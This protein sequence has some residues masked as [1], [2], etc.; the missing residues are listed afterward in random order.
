MG[1]E[2]H[3]DRF[4]DKPQEQWRIPVDEW[5]RPLVYRPRQPEWWS[6]SGEWR[7]VKGVMRLQYRRHLQYLAN[8]D[9]YK[10]NNPWGLD[11]NEREDGFQSMSRDEREE[12][13]IICQQEMDKRVS[14]RTSSDTWQE[15]SGDLPRGWSI[16]EPGQDNPSL[17]NIP[18]EYAPDGTRVI[19]PARIGC[20]RLIAKAT[21]EDEAQE[22]SPMVEAINC[23]RGWRNALRGAVAFCA[24]FCDG[25]VGC[26]VAH[27]PADR[28]LLEKLG[29]LG[30]KYHLGHAIRSEVYRAAI[31]IKAHGVEG[32]E[33]VFREDRFAVHCDVS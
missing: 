21:M 1:F 25:E 3:D 9:S 4:Q 15:G 17:P 11:P 33:P 5:A 7:L 10:P 22:P 20:Y 32:A 2:P 23:Y 18:V 14:G 26:E 6:D 16:P 12:Y 28:D 13:K 8:T 19:I 30:Q 29:E 31:A 24:Q 27:A